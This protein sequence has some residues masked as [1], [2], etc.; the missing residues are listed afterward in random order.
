MATQLP[1]CQ[2]ALFLGAFFVG[3]EI[4]RNAAASLYH[5]IYHKN[6]ICA[7]LPTYPQN[8]P[9]LHS[10]ASQPRFTACLHIL[11]SQPRFTACLHTCLLFQN[12]P[13]LRA[14]FRIDLA[15]R[16]DIFV[17][18]FWRA[19]WLP[20]QNRQLCPDYPLIHDIFVTP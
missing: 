16:H 15:R 6:L 20:W 8:I 12:L 2:A 10:L 5:Q 14:E 4:R 9:P 18:A 13:A 19:P 11:P 17:I 7:S 1:V 3:Q